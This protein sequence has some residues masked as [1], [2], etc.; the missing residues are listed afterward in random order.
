MLAFLLAAPFVLWTEVAPT[1]GKEGYLL[2]VRMAVPTPST[3]QLFFDVGKGIREEDSSRQPVSGGMRSY[4]FYVPSGTLR[5]LRFDPGVTGGRYTIESAVIVR[6]NGSEVRRLDLRSISTLNQLE[7]S[8]RDAD[9]LVLDSPAA[10]NDP[11]FFFNFAGPLEL[12]SSA[13]TNVQLSLPTS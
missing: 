9:E 11:F 4:D 3:G 12:K 10:S 13:T 8:R 7:V 2:R 5:G 1:A 6:S